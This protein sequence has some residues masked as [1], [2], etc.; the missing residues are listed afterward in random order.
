VRYE[1][2]EEWSAAV[3]RFLR[4]RGIADRDHLCLSDL[5]G[6][7]FLRFPDG[8]VAVFVH[9]AYLVSPRKNQVLVCSEGRGPQA[10]PLSGLTI[11]HDAKSMLR[12][13]G[14]HLHK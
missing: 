6:T 14:S 11:T 13:F 1:V 3:R 2:P 7:V 10:Y 12:L 5:S 8:F 4:Q 9:A